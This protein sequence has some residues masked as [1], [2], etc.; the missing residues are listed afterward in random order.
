MASPTSTAMMLDDVTF[1]PRAA[2][3]DLVLSYDNP[4][5]VGLSYDGPT[6]KELA[7][8]SKRGKFSEVSED[9]VKLLICTLYNMARAEMSEKVQYVFFQ[10]D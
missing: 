6:L 4:T 1:D 10:S 9:S 5:Q 3:A 2:L 8:K 7:I